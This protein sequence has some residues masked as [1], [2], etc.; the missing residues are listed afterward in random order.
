MRALRLALVLSGALLLPGCLALAAAAGAAAAYGYVQYTDNEAYRDYRADVDATFDAAT[1]VLRQQGY[2]VPA[3]TFRSVGGEVDVDDV[4]L[5]VTANSSKSSR[6]TV[7]VGTF[8][9]QAHKDR[10]GRILESIAIR[11]GE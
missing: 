1:S 4:K 8:S 2:H 5:K 10:A 6:V 7:R 3:S 11:L 9:T